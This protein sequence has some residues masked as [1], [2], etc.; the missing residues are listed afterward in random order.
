MDIKSFCSRLFNKS[1]A[2]ALF[3]CA[4][5]C[6][7]STSAQQSAMPELR[8][9]FDE[10]ALN[11]DDYIA[12]TV[13]VIDTDKS[14]TFINARFKTRGATARQY[15]EK[16]AMNMKLV[17]EKGEE[18]DFNLLGLRTASSFILDAMAIDRINM[19]NRVCFDIWND[20]SKL[21]YETDFGSRNGTVGRFAEI[22]INNKYKGI[23]CVTDKI[24]RKLLGLKKPKTD[25]DGNLS[26]IRGV[27]YKHGTNDIENQNDPGFF[28]GGMIYIPLWHD[29]WELHEPDDYPCEEV[30]EPLVR[31]YS[32]G[33]NANYNYVKQHF[34]LQNLADYTV[35]LMALSIADNWGSKN[36]Y[37]SAVNI[38][39]DGDDSRFIVTPWDLD[40]SLGGEY[41]GSKYDGDYLDWPLEDIV[42]KA[43]LPFGTVI[44]NPEFTTMMKQTWR[45]NRTGAF[46]VATVKKR[47]QDY[48]DLFISSGAWDRTLAL[49]RNAPYSGEMYVTDLQK[50]I[51]GIGK[52]YEARFDQMDKFFGIDSSQDAVTDVIADF[53]AASPT[54]IFNLQGMRVE[55]ATTPG[56]YIV[57]GKK[58]IKK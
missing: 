9:V 19:R 56:V 3:M 44:A 37:F 27:L 13:T 7:I 43:P 29:A 24:N 20:F 21:P 49:W 11:Y 58:L 28:L 42:N 18:Y 17:D 46:A 38:Q 33:N 45:D 22:Y 54:A 57:N 52:W 36:K 16:P 53:E 50:E 39:K 30:W 31:Y 2:A 12:G 1:A 5:V 6:T 51:D 48:A 40:T 26:E 25:D 47:L 35:H 8:L 23:Y 32:D 55:A 41:D 15:P 34:Y 14:E 4:L 10:E